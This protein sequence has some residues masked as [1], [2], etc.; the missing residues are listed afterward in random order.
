ML[1][2]K[3]V[4]DILDEALSTGGDFA[5]VF[6][7]DSKTRNLALGDGKVE[8]AGTNLLRGVGIRV[9]KGMFQAYAYTNLPDRESLLKTARKAAAAITGKAEKKVINLVDLAFEDKHKIRNFPFEFDRVQEADIYRKV[10]EKMFAASPLI[11]RTDVSGGYKKRRILV[12]NSDGVWAEDEQNRMRIVMSA[13]AV[14]DNLNEQASESN[15]GGLFGAEIFD[16]YNLEEIAENVVRR[17]VN[18]LDAQIC[19]TGTMPVVIGNEFGGVIFHEACGHSLEA[20]SVAPGI[21][22]FSGK[23]GQKIAS[24][25]VT[26]VDD[27]TIPNAWGS[28]N[29]D[30][31]GTPTQ[32][33]VLIENGILKNYMVDKF[34]GRRMKMPSN[35][36]SRREN[37]KF[38]PTSRMSNTFILNGKSTEEEIIAAT[39]YG[40][41]AQKMS[42]G[43]V[44]PTTGEFNFSIDEAYL[45]ENGKITTQVKGAKLIGHGADILPNIDM[46]GNNMAYACGMCGSI[47]GSIP[48]TVG[49]PA[50]RVKELT[51]GGQ[52]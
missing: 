38:I 50:I 20:T 22:E 4:A 25:L 45:I 11:S 8:S 47:S 39:P 49:Q 24:D 32:R 43:S 14:R 44:H 27:A 9:F 13:I 48:T 46:V 1:D 23:L 10:S 35:G 37:Y 28:I 19:P 29:I 40:L 7:E 52:K 3:L 2:K 31:E 15:I 34:G 36:A 5:E 17:A 51:V 33:K 41:Y 42:G 16:L 30:D 6:A 21:S 26:A 12:A 18:K